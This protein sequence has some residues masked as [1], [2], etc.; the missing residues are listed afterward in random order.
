MSDSSMTDS[1]NAKHQP[2]VTVRISPKLDKNLTTYVAVA[3]A[4]GVGLL[5][6]GQLAEAKIVYT[7]ANVTLGRNSTYVLDLNNDGIPDFEITDFFYQ[8][9][10]VPSGFHTNVLSIRP[11][12]QPNRV[13]ETTSGGRQ[14][15][16]PLSPPQS[17][18]PPQPISSQLLSQGICLFSR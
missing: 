15:S 16:L 3:S 9:A 6:A 7:P 12:K 18:R 8:V 1:T 10:R 14:F 2:L 13:V 5:A 11:Q 4:A 17:G